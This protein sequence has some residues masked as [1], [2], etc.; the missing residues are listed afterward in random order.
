[1][2]LFW[3]VSLFVLTLFDGPPLPAG[4]LLLWL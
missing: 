2:I 1:L 4:P 3:S